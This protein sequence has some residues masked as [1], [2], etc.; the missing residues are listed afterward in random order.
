MSMLKLKQWLDDNDPYLI[1]R[2]GLYKA[3]FTATIMVYAYW[4]FLPVN[5]IAYIVLLIILARYESPIFYSNQER[6][7]HFIFFYLA[8]TICSL[9]F[10]MLYP[11][12]LA[13][14]GYALLLTS[15]IYFIIAGYYPKI[16]NTTMMIIGIS[17]MSL[18]IQPA[19][20]W[21]EAYNLFSGQT[22]SY[23]V[24]LNCLLLF[25]NV[26]PLTWKRAILHYL[27]CLEVDIEAN[28][29]HQTPSSVRQEVAHIDI[30]LSHQ[31]KL[32]R[33][34]LNPSVR[35]YINLRNIHFALSPMYQREEDVLFW[36]HVLAQLHQLHNHIRDNR[37]YHPP[38][39]VIDESNALQMKVNAYLLKTIKAWNRLCQVRKP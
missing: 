10:Y 29:K 32:P 26:Y 25:P 6:Y 18:N 7:R 5:A 37:D 4:I 2:L 13:F 11:H 17:S 9:S 36:Q 30:I 8:T 3:L 21:Q 28:I 22:L 35:I 23:L 20:N 19:A 14:I 24:L 38:R 39:L 12:H 31:R 15:L 27:H 33:A 1:Q 16:K 34:Q